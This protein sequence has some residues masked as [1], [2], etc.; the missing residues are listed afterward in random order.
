MLPS[1]VTSKFHPFLAQERSFSPRNCFLS[2]PKFILVNK[3]RELTLKTVL[4][5]RVT[6]EDECQRTRAL[7]RLLDRIEFNQVRSPE[8]FSHNTT[9]RKRRLLTALKSC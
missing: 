8:S 7:I 4:Q 2:Q 5:F 1:T 3:Q 6:L 9:S